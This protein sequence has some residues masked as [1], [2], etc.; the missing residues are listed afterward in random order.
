MFITRFIHWLFMY[1]VFKFASTKMMRTSSNQINCK[2]VTLLIGAQKAGTSSMQSIL[3][4]KK[5]I[6]VYPGESLYFDDYYLAKNKH[7]AK[8]ILKKKSSKEFI[9]LVQTQL[10]KSKKQNKAAFTDVIVKSPNPIMHPEIAD[11]IVNKMIRNGTKAFALLRDPTARMISGYFQ[12]Q[13]FADRY[14][15]VGS[16][17]YEFADIWFKSDRYNEFNRELA[18][19]LVEY[20]HNRQNSTSILDKLDDYYRGWVEG[21]DP[22]TRGCYAPQ[23]VSW[24]RD[25]EGLND[26]NRFKHSFKIV[27][28]ERFF[29]AETF[30]RTM[31]YVECYI[32]YHHQQNGDNYEKVMAAEECVDGNNH[33]KYNSVKIQSKTKSFVPSKHLLDSINESYKVCN[34]WLTELLQNDLH[35]KN[36]ILDDFDWTLW[37]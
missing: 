30:Q 21:Y 2:N 18:H 15:T 13:A 35:F 1:A 10:N 31:V 19:L 22:W 6:F 12:D 29:A 23:L 20:R 14:P 34:E 25:I 17:I 33:P 37:N 8:E 9:K 16:D 27:Q 24:I 11:V 5:S 28:S 3:R 7:N 32:Q 36:I 4:Q 26:E